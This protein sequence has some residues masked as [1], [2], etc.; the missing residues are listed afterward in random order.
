MSIAPDQRHVT[1][2]ELID[3][4]ELR[5]RFELVDGQL[6]EVHVSNLS[7]AVEARLFRLLSNHCFDNQLG[8]VLGSGNY[9]Q[10]FPEAERKGR[11]PDISFISNER[12]PGDWLEQGF[13]TIAPDL[14]TEVVSQ[15]DTKY[16]VDKKIDEYL[17]AGVKI[18]WEVNPMQRS[19][20][21]Y[22]LDGT[23][24]KLHAADSLSGEDVIPGFTCRVVDFLPE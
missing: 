8:E 21:I 1:L 11:K 20:L 12:L 7:N 16:E 22:R 13:F 17:A 18:V 2:Q 5:G 3:S 19:V 9:Y 24:Q 6:E 23:V 14:A 15:N 10:C 4:E